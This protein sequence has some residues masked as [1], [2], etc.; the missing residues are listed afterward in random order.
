MPQAAAKVTWKLEDKLHNGDA[1]MLQN[2]LD[3]AAARDKF[4]DG[5]TYSSSMVKVSLKN[6]A[7]LF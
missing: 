4:R 6:M 1:S 2:F 5:A 7:L 3:M